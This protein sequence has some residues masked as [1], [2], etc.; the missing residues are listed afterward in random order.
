M[1]GAHL[2]VDAPRERDDEGVP[3]ALVDTARLEAGGHCSVTMIGKSS[4]VGWIVS[5]GGLLEGAW[6][7]L[8]SIDVREIEDSGTSGPLGLRW[9]TFPS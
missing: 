4:V 9:K 2:D 8:I 7:L 5:G 1:P 6:S 3:I